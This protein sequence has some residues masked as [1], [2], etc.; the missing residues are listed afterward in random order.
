MSTKSNEDND[1]FPDITKSQIADEMNKLIEATGLLKDLIKICAEYAEHEY[2]RGWWFAICLEHDYERHFETPIWIVRES[3][4]SNL[5]S[6]PGF[7]WKCWWLSIDE[8]KTRIKNRT[9]NQK[10]ISANLQIALSKT[11]ALLRECKEK[12]YVDSVIINEE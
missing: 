2:L 12:G 7:A 4:R 1:F 10:Q 9:M 6:L 8:I 5:P 3:L 11:N